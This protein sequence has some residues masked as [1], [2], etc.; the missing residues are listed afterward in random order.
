MGVWNTG[1]GWLF[2]P[3]ELTVK[4]YSHRVNAMFDSEINKVMNTSVFI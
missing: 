2:I 3:C 4:P 1:N